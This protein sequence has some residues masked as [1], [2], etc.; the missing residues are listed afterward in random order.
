[1][2]LSYGGAERKGVLPSLGQI[3]IHVKVE[4]NIF[5][6]SRDGRIPMGHIHVGHLQVDKIDMV[7]GGTALNTLGFFNQGIVDFLYGRKLNFIQWVQKID[8]L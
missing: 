3:T 4:I 6:S 5:S 2:I 1:M 7:L 8:H